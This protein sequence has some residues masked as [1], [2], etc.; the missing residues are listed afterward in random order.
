[1]AKELTREEMAGKIVGLLNVAHGVD[2]AT[3]TCIL[4]AT[5]N[6]EE[7]AMKNFFNYICGLAEALS[8]TSVEG[9]LYQMVQQMVAGARITDPFVLSEFLRKIKK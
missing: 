9:A 6:L 3:R 4:H 7:E 1:M 5:E 8:I 2:P